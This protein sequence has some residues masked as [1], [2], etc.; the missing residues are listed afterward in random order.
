MP[1][2]LIS[3]LTSSILKFVRTAIIFYKLYFIVISRYFKYIRLKIHVRIVALTPDL[4]R[5]SFCN[6]IDPL[7]YSL[8][9]TLLLPLIPIKEFIGALRPFINIR[10]IVIS[11]VAAVACRFIQDRQ[12]GRY[13][14]RTSDQSE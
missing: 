3:T 13:G 8:T 9:T 10:E 12:A 7:Y 4:Q 2:N 11:L 14:F 1:E 6:E 5:V